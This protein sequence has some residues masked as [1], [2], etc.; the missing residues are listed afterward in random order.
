MAR[1]ANITALAAAHSIERIFSR[2][3]WLGDA[4]ELLARLG[5]TRRELRRVAD[6]DEVSAALETRRHAAINTPW[7]VESPRARVRDFMTRAIE[8]HVI[9]ILTAAW[10][11]V[12][13]GYAVF[14]IVYARG[15]GPNQ[16]RVL[17]DRIIPCP[18]E[19]FVLKPDG[20]ILWADTR[21]EADPRKFVAVA[22][23]ATL[24]KPM[25]EA[26]LAKAYWPWYFRTHGWRLWAKFLEQSAVPLLIGR[27]SGMR[28]VVIEALAKVTSG[29]SIVVDGDGD[30]KAVATP[31]AKGGQFAEFELGCVRRIQRL[32]L[33][34][35]LTSGTDGGAGNRALGEVHERVRDEKRRADIRLISRAVQEVLDRLAVLNGLPEAG[36]FVMEDGVGLEKERAAR[37][38]ILHRIGVRFTERYMREKFGLEE[39]DF[40]IEERAAGQGDN[41]VPSAMALSAEGPFTEGQQIIEDTVASLAGNAPQPVSPEAIASAIRGARD[42]AD[43]VARLGVAMAGADDAAFRQVLERAMTG[44]EITG[45]I[46]AERTAED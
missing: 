22:S 39:D 16:G 28:D 24:R 18:F 41:A 20:R 27:T 10:E 2:F 7:R 4:D 11:A 12:P 35:T 17:I 25:G 38:E 33:G 14:E 26:L 36:R 29:P 46:E 45:L 32:I 34:Q 5:I 6:D 1:R 37:D 15:A 19:W 42:E 9:D 8:P 43:L 21:L 31:G 13:Y 23:G 30:V 3:S 44:A 40:R